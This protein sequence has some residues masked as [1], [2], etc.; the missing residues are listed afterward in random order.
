MAETLLERMRART[1]EEEDPSPATEAMIKKSDMLLQ[2]ELE[3]MA[4]EDRVKAEVLPDY[5]AEAFLVSA[6]SRLNQ[7]GRGIKK[8]FGADTSK[9]DEE[10]ERLMAPVEEKYPK[11][12][13]AGGLVTDMVA[14]APLGLGAGAATSKGLATVGAKIAPWIERG[15]TG[16]ATGTTEGAAVGLVDDNPA[17]G[18]ILGGGLGA[19]LSIAIP[20][21]FRGAS[22]LIKKLLGKT[23]DAFVA[24]S[25]GAFKPSDELDKS[26]KKLG[27]TLDDIKGADLSSLPDKMTPDEM[28]RKILFDVN[29]TP[30]LRSRITQNADD[31][32]GQVRVERMAGDE[33]ADMVRQRLSQESAG[34]QNRLK[35]LSDDLGVSDQAGGTIKGAL[36]KLD[37]GQSAKIKSAYEALTKLSKESNA[38]AIPLTRKHIR[39]A[40][41]EVLFGTKPVNDE[42]RNAIK[43]AAAKFGVLGDDVTK[44]GSMTTVRYGGELIDGKWKGG[45]IIQFNGNQTP[46]NLGNFE[47]FRKTLN[48][49]FQRDTTGS[50]TSIKKAVDNTILEAT[51]ILE[52]AADDRSFIKTLAE[53]ARQTVIGRKELLDTGSLVPKLLNNNPTTGS[54][55]V[56]ASKVSNKI[57]SQATPSEEVERLISAL[58]KSGESG[59]IAVKNLQADTVMRLMDKAFKNAGKLEGGQTPFNITAFSNELKSIGESKLGHIFKGNPAAIK[60]LKQ[61]EEMGKLMRTPSSAVQKGSAPDMINALIRAGR[62]TGALSGSITSMAA[63]SAAGTVLN[64]ANKRAVQKSII[65]LTGLNEAAAAR[66]MTQTYPE[67]AAVLGLTTALTHEAIDE[68]APRK[69]L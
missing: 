63:S 49:A 12:T 27:L 19:T 18:A 4:Y 33:G 23:D 65:G 68:G 54:P 26:L 40:V 53:N 1:S 58:S 39:D 37:S 60:V 42:T 29:E 14:T 61:V 43:R 17:A 47:E 21:A 55:F 31:F 44:K 48:Q 32:A 69:P 20:P 16:L 34:I 15:I 45:E 51:N 7:Y 25:S 46:L 8:I 59:K 5:P 3:N 36:T 64:I 38:S 22:K 11:S 52:E 2:Q 9:A 6:G 13:Y 24:T 28:A 35:R 66:F 56:E 67:L 50:V 30:T 57:F 10:D 41:D 62:T